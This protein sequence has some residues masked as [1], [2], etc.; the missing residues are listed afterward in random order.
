MKKVWKNKT[1]I[2]LFMLP[3]TV[4]FVGII[5]APIIMSLKYSFYNWNG[6][7]EAKFVGFDNYVRLFTDKS[8]YFLL[9]MKNVLILAFLSVFLQLP[10]SFL[11]A[12]KLATGIRGEKFFVGVYFAPVL[13]SGVVIGQLWLKI[14]NANYGLVNQVLRFLKLDEYAH[15]WLG[16]KKYALMAVFI[17]ILWQYVGYHMLLMYAGIKAI[18]PDLREAAMIDGASDWQVTRHIVL[19]LLKPVIKV[20]VIFAVV[21]SL[22]SFDLIYNL[23]G[24][25]PAHATEVPST[26]LVSQLFGRNQYG[27]GS[28]IAVSIIALCF[29]FAMIIQAAFRDKTQD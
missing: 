10:L 3:A 11:L 1:A 21:G 27:F 14:Y 6:F 18:S 15:V 16:D 19:P 29:L 8:E 25:N 12:N 26:L 22:K 28:S 23:T 20:C 24:G 2:F 9:S 17:P 13:I 4:F 5:I 7:T